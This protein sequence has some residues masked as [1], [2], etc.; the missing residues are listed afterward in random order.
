VIKQGG[1]LIT[2]QLLAATN[3]LVGSNVPLT[4]ASIAAVRLE[5]VDVTG[6]DTPAAAFWLVYFHKD[7]PSSRAAP[8]PIDVQMTETSTGAQ[9]SGVLNGRNINGATLVGVADIGKVYS[10]QYKHVAG[11]RVQIYAVIT[12]TFTAGQGFTVNSDLS[13]SA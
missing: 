8:L 3:G 6:T 9:V 7:Y 10:A 5:I 2:Q 12:G 1:V 11:Y 13:A 4:T